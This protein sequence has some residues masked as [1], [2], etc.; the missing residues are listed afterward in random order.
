MLLL[1]P[2]DAPRGKSGFARP[3]KGGGAN[4]INYNGGPVMVDPLGVKAYIIW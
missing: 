2:A 4:G 1:L 3:S